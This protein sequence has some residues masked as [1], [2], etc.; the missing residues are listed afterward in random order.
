MLGTGLASTLLWLFV[1]AYGLNFSALRP[2]WGGRERLPARV[3]STGQFTLL[4]GENARRTCALF[5]YQGKVW[6]AAAYGETS[7]APGQ[8]T[9]VLV[10]SAQP[11]SAWI[12]GL[13]KFPVQ[14][15]GIARMAMVVFSPGLLL[16]LW[17]LLAGRRQEGLLRQGAEVMGHRVRH[18]SLPRP[19]SDRFLDQFE[20]VAADGSRR[21]MWSVGPNGP[22]ETRLLVAPGRWRGA[23]VI[24][25][26][27]PQ[28]GQVATIRRAGAWLVI[29]LALAQLGVLSLFLWT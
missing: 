7:L 22:P 15:T 25:H 19:L 27:L 29:G 5:S 28:N 18:L 9:S 24:S 8:E 26:L 4:T 10:P 2:L 21:R 1:A 13:Q 23:V 16:C 11:E 12:E 17:G 14:L 3:E 20:L 6:R